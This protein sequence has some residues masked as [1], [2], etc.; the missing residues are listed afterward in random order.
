M[1]HSKF[2]KMF[3]ELTIRDFEMMKYL[4]MLPMRSNQSNFYRFLI[5]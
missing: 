5:S 2:A 4:Y 3:E 1:I